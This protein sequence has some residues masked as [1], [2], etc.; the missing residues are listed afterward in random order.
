KLVA[1][2]FPEPA[3]HFHFD[4]AQGGFLEDPAAHFGDSF[5]AVGENDRHFHHLETVHDGHEL[6]LNL[7]SVT[8]GPYFVQVDGFQYLSPVAFEAGC[9][10]ADIHSGNKPDIHRS[11]I[12]HQHPAH[13][14][15]YDVYA[16]DVTGS[17]GQVRAL[18]AGLAQAGQVFGV[19]RE[20]RIHFKDK[21]IGPLQ[22]PSESVNIGSSQPH[23]SVPLFQE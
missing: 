23:F 1:F 14:P 9:E 16:F 5:G 7:E 18:Q 15:V 2:N 17:H 8:D 6:H 13:G 11:A 4:H 22:R 21:L 10:I 20:V 12:G 3:A 19:V